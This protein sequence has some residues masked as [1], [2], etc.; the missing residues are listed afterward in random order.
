MLSK[1]QYAKFNGCENA[2][3]LG[4]PQGYFIFGINF[5]CSAV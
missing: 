1:K 4:L 3:L 5:S 2:R